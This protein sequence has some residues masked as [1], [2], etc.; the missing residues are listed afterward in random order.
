M[1]HE[2]AL[3][4]KLRYEP[5]FLTVHDIVAFARAAASSARGAGRRPIRSS[6]SR[7]A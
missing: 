6:A 7:W 5:Y 3:I 2:L 4:A 1:A